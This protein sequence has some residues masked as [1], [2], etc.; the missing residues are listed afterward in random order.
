MLW[1]GLARAR[2]R[3]AILKLGGGCDGDV[4]AEGLQVADQATFACIGV[5]VA[6]EVV[7]A[8]IAVLDVVVQH[9][10]GDHDEG[11]GDG[12]GGLPAA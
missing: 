12:D 9:V 6:G 1:C 2:W 5:V 8:Q 11:V 10:P 7:R 4:V 3:W